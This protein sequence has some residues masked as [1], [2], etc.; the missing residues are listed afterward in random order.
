MIMKYLMSSA[1]PLLYIIPTFLV[2]LNCGCLASYAKCTPEPAP[3]TAPAAFSLSEL[4]DYYY[5]PPSDQSPADLISVQVSES[6]IRNKLS[7]YSLA[8]DGK[9]FTRLD[10]VFTE[11]VVANFSEPIGVVKGLANVKEVVREALEGVDTQLLLG[12][13]LIEVDPKNPCTAKSLT[14]FAST[15]FG[16]GDQKGKV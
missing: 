9:N 1:H 13:Q 3:A 16:T 8:L 12:T 2:L 15:F 6:Q 11:D 14:Y 10:Y 7:L 4:V 5:E